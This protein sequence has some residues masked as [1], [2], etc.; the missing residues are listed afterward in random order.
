MENKTICPECSEA[1]VV[2]GIYNEMPVFV[3]PNG[4]RSMFEEAA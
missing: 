2:D 1:L 4:H 3:C